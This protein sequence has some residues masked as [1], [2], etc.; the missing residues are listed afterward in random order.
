M[1][2]AWIE[3]RARVGSMSNTRSELTPSS[4]M[5]G[6]TLDDVD[7]GDGEVIKRRACGGSGYGNAVDFVS[8][9]ACGL[10]A[11]SGVVRGLRRTMGMCAV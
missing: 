8:E 5:E 10:S 7:M 1:R 3:D 11:V 2:S 4:K 9:V 6:G